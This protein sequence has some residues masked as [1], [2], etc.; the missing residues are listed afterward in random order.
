MFIRCSLVKFIVEQTIL[1][2]I[3]QPGKIE[4]QMQM[5]ANQVTC[6]V[7]STAKDPVNYPDRT[8]DQNEQKL[9]DFKID[10]NER[11]T[12]VNVNVQKKKS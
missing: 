4:K 2:F 10:D 3:L 1:T 8:V 11:P 7:L 6:E 5:I 12:M 9:I